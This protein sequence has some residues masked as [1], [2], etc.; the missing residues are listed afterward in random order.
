MPLYIKLN[1]LHLFLSLCGIQAFGATELAV[2]CE[3][4]FLQRMPNF[5]EIEDFQSLLRPSSGSP[6]G[7]SQLLDPP[8]L[9]GLQ[10]TLSRRLLSLCVPGQG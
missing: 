3:G 5:L 1:A 7:G 4:Y 8:P 6:A 10:T 2:F 9:E